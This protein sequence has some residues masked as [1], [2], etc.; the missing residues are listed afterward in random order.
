MLNFNVGSGYTWISGKPQWDWAA[1]W[2]DRFFHNRLGIMASASY[3]YAPGGSDNTEFEYEEN[4][5]KDLELK[6]AQVRQYC[7]TRE[8]QSYSLAMD[9]KFSRF[10]VSRSRESI[11][12]VATGKTVIASAIRN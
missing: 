2:G 1:T 8:R 3:Q 7:V 6:E 12:A 5:D 10:T 4:D 11:I 9:Y